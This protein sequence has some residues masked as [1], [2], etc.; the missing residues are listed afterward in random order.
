[1]GVVAGTLIGL[2][3]RK[4]NLRVERNGVRLMPYEIGALI[5]FSIDLIYFAYSI[6]F[7][8]GQW[9]TVNMT[10]FW[11]RQ[12]GG[13]LLYVPIIGI[14]AKLIANRAQPVQSAI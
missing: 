9:E 10:L 14:V 7:Q 2:V 13:F 5:G 3:Y 6:N 12:F 1:M 8:P 4:A 11:I